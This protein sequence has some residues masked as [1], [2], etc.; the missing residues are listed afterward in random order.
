MSFSLKFID[1]GSLLVIEEN[2]IFWKIWLIFQKAI[3]RPVDNTVILR[4]PLVSVSRNYLFI[5]FIDKTLLAV[6]L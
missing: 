4:A 5:Y 1:P 2:I 6:S 3:V